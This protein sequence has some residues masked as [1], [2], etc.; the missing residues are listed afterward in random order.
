MKKEPLLQAKDS[1]ISIKSSSSR[2]NNN[3]LQ[4]EYQIKKKQYIS[5]YGYVNKDPID[6]GNCFS[7]FFI[8]WAYRILKLS[9]LVNIE[10]THLGK[11]SKDHSS[12]TYFKN[13]MLFWQRKGYQKIKKCPLLWTSL[14]INL[15][16]LIVAFF[17]TLIS[18]FLSIANLYLFRLFIKI[19]LHPNEPLS[20]RDKYIGGAYLITRFIL[21]VLNQKLSQF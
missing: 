18:S 4:E 6:E 20:I 19:F 1:M 17:L 11:F 9:N 8:Y 2:K 12:A 16:N 15:S 5:K 14:R 7:N 21:I 13:L 3:K 10:S